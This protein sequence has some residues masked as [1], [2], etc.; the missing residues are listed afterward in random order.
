[1]RSLPTMKW[2]LLSVNSHF[3]INSFYY[4]MHSADKWNCCMKCH[5]EMNAL[6]TFLIVTIGHLSCDNI[7]SM[8]LTDF[9][10]FHK[11]IIYIICYMVVVNLLSTCADIN[12]IPYKRLSPQYFREYILTIYCLHLLHEKTLWI[13]C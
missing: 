13:I 12:F 2:L 7:Q 8:C 6:I 5:I 4:D 11:Y 3:V 1:M 10:N 9:I